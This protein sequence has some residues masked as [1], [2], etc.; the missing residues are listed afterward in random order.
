MI[1]AAVYVVAEAELLDIFASKLT[2]LRVWMTTPHLLPRE[3]D[4][5]P[6]SFAVEMF[7]DENNF[8]LSFQS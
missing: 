4:K 5:N 3:T 8:P 7:T 2:S 1:N 6:F